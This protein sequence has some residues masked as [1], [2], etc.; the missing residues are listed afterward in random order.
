M[1]NGKIEVVKNDPSQVD[2]RLV[3][4]AARGRDHVPGH[5]ERAAGGARRDPY[6]KEYLYKTLPPW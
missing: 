4:G 5:G 3:H 2:G 1:V 6:L